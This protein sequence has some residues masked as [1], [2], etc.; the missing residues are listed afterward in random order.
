MTRKGD[1]THSNNGRDKFY[2]EVGYLEEGRVE[3]IQEVDEQP[4]DMRT[5]VI[6]LFL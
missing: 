2:E 3:M 4:L 1:D 5:V 6:L